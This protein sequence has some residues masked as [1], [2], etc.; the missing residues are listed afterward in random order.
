MNFLLGDPYYGYAKE[1]FMRLSIPNAKIFK[2]YVRDELNRLS[3]Y[4][5]SIGCMEHDFPS[6]IV[7]V[8][9]PNKR[10]ERPG[11]PLQNSQSS[12]ESWKSIFS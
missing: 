9:K 7:P 6:T 5:E 12:R 10:G 8:L 1:R 4:L 2:E 11:D 3:L